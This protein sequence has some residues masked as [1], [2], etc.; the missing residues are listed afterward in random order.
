VERL[1]LPGEAGNTLAVK[2]RSCRIPV[3]FTIEANWV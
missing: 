2:D 1:S 3:L